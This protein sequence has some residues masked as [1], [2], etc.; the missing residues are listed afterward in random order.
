M[1]QMQNVTREG[2]PS[3]T[4]LGRLWAGI[5]NEICNFLVIFAIG[6]IAFIKYDSGPTMG[7][8][9]FDVLP[10]CNSKLVVGDLP[11]AIEEN[12]LLSKILN[13][14]VFDVQFP[15]ERVGSN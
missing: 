1:V 13:I 3:N 2:A 4:H 9:L 14:K 6:V 8:G 5:F 11:R 15:R 12:N 7:N 10:D